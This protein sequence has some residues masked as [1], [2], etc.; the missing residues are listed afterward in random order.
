M[1]KSATTA[2]ALAL[3][4]IA[5]TAAAQAPPAQKPAEPQ[6]ET[7]D[8][9]ACANARAD[10]D[11]KGD[12]E[13]RDP[14]DRT[15]SEQLAK[16]DGVICPPPAVDPAIHAPTPDTGSNTPVIPPPGSTDPTIRPK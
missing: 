13:V 5:L 6:R 15:L 10:I 1:R 7:R 12:V 14:K 16:S 2:A 4:V 11:K 3:S 8:P 9:T